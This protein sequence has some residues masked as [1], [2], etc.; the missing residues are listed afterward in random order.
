MAILTA[1]RSAMESKRLIYGDSHV[2]SKQ[3]F[4]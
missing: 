1:F 4:A 3:N 2:Y